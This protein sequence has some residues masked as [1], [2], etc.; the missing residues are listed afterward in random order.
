MALSGF[1]DTLNEQQKRAFEQMHATVVASEFAQDLAAHPASNR[2]LLKFLRATAK[3]KTGKREFIPAD[4]YKRM[5]ISFLWRREHKI[6]AL[7]QSCERDEPPEKWELYRD[8][9]PCLDVI[10][11]ETG[12]LMRFQMLGMFA[13]GV[14][15]SLMT[16][17]EWLQ[18]LCYDSLNIEKI[19]RRESLRLGHEKGTFQ[20][21]WYFNSIV[22]NSSLPL[23]CS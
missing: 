15:L 16:N 12:T 20:A 10:N 23:T 14:D 6:D 2:W 13:S 18:C 3:D 19:L 8:C 7:M 9:Y 22:P 5:K 21:A 11:P 4:A 17:E 1:E